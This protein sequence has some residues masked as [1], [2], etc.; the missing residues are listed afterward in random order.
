MCVEIVINVRDETL[1]SSM[2]PLT[3]KYLVNSKIVPEQHT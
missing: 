1:F 3:T 2:A